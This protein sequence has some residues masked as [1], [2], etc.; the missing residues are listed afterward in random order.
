MLYDL[1]SRTTAFS[2][3]TSWVL[4]AIQEIAGS[5]SLIAIPVQGSATFAVE[6]MLTGLLNSADKHLLLAVNGDY[7]H[8][9]MEICRIH[10][11]RITAM[12]SDPLSPISLS[13]IERT[14]ARDRSITHVAAAHFETGLGV[15]NDVDGLISI[16]ERHNVSVLVDAVSTFGAISIN[17]RSPAVQALAVSANKCLH[18]VPGV[19]FVIVRENALDSTAPPRTLSLDLHAQHAELKR[20]GQ[21]RFTPPIQVMLALA[22]AIEEFHLQ[23]GVQGR[24]ARYRRLTDRLVH[25]LSQ[26]GILPL[27]PD[28]YRAPMIT[29]FLL[30]PGAPFSS[31]TIVAALAQRGLVAYPSRYQ[32]RD[33]FRVG[34]MGDLTEVDIDH[35]VCAV[36]ELMGK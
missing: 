26:L 34:C 1:G 28:A 10:G 5:D 21:W 8:R 9:M 17:N 20:S 33:S 16:A 12:D 14:L 6:A 35:L 22:H 27:I 31:G 32:A 36:R 11:L 18:S 3:L 23:G 30:E 15:L 13:Q 24:F 19:S 29:T 4:N 25:G 2:D 7:S